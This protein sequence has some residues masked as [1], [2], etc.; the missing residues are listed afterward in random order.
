[1]STAFMIQ[2]PRMTVAVTVSSAGISEI[3]DQYGYRPASVDM[4]TA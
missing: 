1:M 4:S 3:V 2:D